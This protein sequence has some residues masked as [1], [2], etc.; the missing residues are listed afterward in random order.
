MYERGFIDRDDLDYEAEDGYEGYSDEEYYTQEHPRDRD[1]RGYED[2]DSDKE[3]RR[4][5]TATLVEI[6]TILCKDHGKS[7]SAD[8][9]RCKISIDVL[10]GPQRCQSYG[11][12][13]P[14]TNPIP[15]ASAVLERVKNM[16]H[17]KPTLTLSQNALDYGHTAYYS[18][19]M[20]K[21]KHE[22]IIREHLFL[23][24]D[25]NSYLMDNLQLE[26]V[27]AGKLKN[28]PLMELKNLAVKFGKNDRWAQRALLKTV[29]KTE[30][31]VRSLRA[32]GTSN[33]FKYPDVVP[34]RAILGPSEFEDYLSYESADPF[35]LPDEV[36]VL[37]GVEGL[38]DKD[39]ETILNNLE[40]QQESF[41]GFLFEVKQH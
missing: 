2:S 30:E 22:E 1:Y 27:V 11:L 20:P 40:V 29:S 16:P 21:T 33:C 18:K 39:R 5:S 35:P 36:D 26:E 4:I 32:L 7:I 23:P 17:K 19:P 34:T 41:R 6:E 25:Q 13:V 38:S 24:E 28:G 15:E 10:G 9:S 3:D 12:K 14:E 8:C 31:G 37:D